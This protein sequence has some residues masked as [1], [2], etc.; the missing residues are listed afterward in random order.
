M[1]VELERW[2]AYL[3][4]YTDSRVSVRMPLHGVEY[5]LRSVRLV[6]TD[7]R[8]EYVMM[9]GAK[10]WSWHACDFRVGRDAL[11]V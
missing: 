7:M 10:S 2:V 5:K 8:V 3:T 4:T 11:Q 9:G 1:G 6:W